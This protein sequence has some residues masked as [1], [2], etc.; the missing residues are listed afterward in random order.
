MCLPRFFGGMSVSGQ[1]VNAWVLQAANFTLTAAT[2]QPAV[3]PA[4]SPVR[5]IVQ[6][7][8]AQLTSVIDI[9][10]YNGVAPPASTF[11]VPTFCLN[12]A[13]PLL[14]TAWSMRR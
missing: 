2:L 12:S 11:E 4:Q 7:S 6:S 5:L 8:T 3:D 14:A 1:L 10:G 9:G 13:V